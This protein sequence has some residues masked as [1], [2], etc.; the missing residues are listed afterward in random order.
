MAGDPN[1]PALDRLGRWL[2]THGVEAA[3]E[4]MTPLAG[5]NSNATFLLHCG[6]RRLVLRR[7]PA[8]ALSSSA[9]NMAREYR[10]M[11]ALEGTGVPVPGLVG[12]CADPETVGAPFL[13]M[14]AVDG[15]PLTDSMPE[16]YPAGAAGALGTRMVDTL[17]RLHS[18]DWADLG[19]SDF[20]RPAGFLDRQVARWTGQYRSYATRDL[21]R[22][23]QIARWLAGHSPDPQPAGILHGDYHLDNCLWGRRAPTLLAV[24][25]WE[26]S[27]IGDPLLDLGLCLAFWGDR[28]PEPPGLARIQ[29]LSRQPGTPDRQELADRYA[30]TAGRTVRDLRYYLCLALWKLAAILEGAY[31]QFVAGS[32][33]TPYARG[34]GADVPQLLEEA[35]GHAGL[36]APRCG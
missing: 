5:G 1:P 12:Y 31:S 20:G 13:V 32:L 14:E 29:A 24:I 18:L 26:L 3:V 30:E 34:L 21:P 9:H 6:S 11:R 23:D 2:R 17:A 10:V 19:L 7:P 27:T 25:D 4:S 22:F 36:A 28:E 33:G 35:A 15:V 16:G 8:D